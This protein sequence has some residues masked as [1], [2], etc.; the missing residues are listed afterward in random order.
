MSSVTMLQGNASRGAFH[1]RWRWQGSQLEPWVRPSGGAAT[2]TAW[3]AGSQRHAPSS[4]SPARGLA[5][6]C[7]TSSC[8]HRPPSTPFVQYVCMLPA[9]VCLPNRGHVLLPT[10]P[11]DLSGF[12]RACEAVHAKCKIPLAV[13][14][15]ASH[16]GH[17]CAT[18]A[19]PGE[20]CG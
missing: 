8:R 5:Q 15:S 18:C 12:K 14:E 7:C 1:R 16:A 13:P 10:F 3:L 9:V 19:G 11:A 17:A 4:G 20:G 2:P 6:R